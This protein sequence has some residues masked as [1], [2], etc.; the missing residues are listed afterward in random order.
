M[1]KKISLP[2][3]DTSLHACLCDECKK[4]PLIKCGKC[5]LWKI[6]VVNKT[7]RQ[8]CQVCHRWKWVP[9]A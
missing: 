6:I 5:R 1:P 4:Q 7:S 8:V 3:P 2:N 9:I